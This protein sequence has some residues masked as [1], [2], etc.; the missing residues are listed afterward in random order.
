VTLA[1]AIASVALG[2]W[3]YLIFLHGNFWL[4]DEREEGSAPVS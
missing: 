3:I 4:A 1:V 2:I